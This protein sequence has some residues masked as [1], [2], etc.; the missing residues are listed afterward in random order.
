[1]T[2]AL[3]TICACLA[4]F[5]LAAGLASIGAWA[6]GRGVPEAATRDAA[7]AARRLFVLRVV[8]IAVGLAVGVGLTL[9]GF[10]LFEPRGTGEAAGLVFYVLAAGGSLAIVQAL[11]RAAGDWWTTRRLYRAWT[12][13]AQPVELAG[14][15]VP[16][17]RIRHSFP[18]VSVVGILRPRLFIAEQVLEH[19]SPAE[20][21]AVLAHEAAHVS[22]ADN[23]KRLVVRLCPAL[24]WNAAARSLEERWELAAEEAADARAGAALDLASALVKTARL[25]PAGAR[26]EMSVAAFHRGDA[27][28]RRVRCLVEPPASIPAPPRA[29]PIPPVVGVAVGAAA[30]VAAWPHT[31][32][33]VHRV[34][35]ALVR[36]P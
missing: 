32:P 36:L 21:R 8:P 30:A 12:R 2:F 14:T 6:A 35:E 31:L 1:V 3:W 34:V 29:A 17:F 27:L 19:L 15:P 7:R 13:E 9:P 33:L 25:A 23:V 5:A 20:L 16:A 26:L 22:A 24:P 4:S 11:R 28:A 18:V 10:L